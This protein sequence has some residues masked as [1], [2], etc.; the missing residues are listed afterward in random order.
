MLELGAERSKRKQG[1][2]HHHNGERRRCLAE[3]R[4]SLAASRSM[5]LAIRTPQRASAKLQATRP[6]S[7]LLRARGGLGGI[8]AVTCVQRPVIQRNKG[9]CLSRQAIFFWVS[10]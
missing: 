7:G 9:P 5:R 10:L 1:R 4:S 2:Q 3:K 6:G 8:G